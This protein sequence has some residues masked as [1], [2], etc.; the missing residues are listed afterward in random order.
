MHTSPEAA[1]FQ[2]CWMAACT[3]AARLRQRSSNGGAVAKY[4]FVCFCW[5][6]CVLSSVYLFCGRPF[7]HTHESAGASS[8]STLRCAHDAE[9]RAAPAECDALPVPA[10]EVLNS[11]SPSRRGPTKRGP[12]TRAP[13]HPFGVMQPM[14][15]RSCCSSGPPAWGRRFPARRHD[16]AVVRNRST[17]ALT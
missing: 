7:V 8:H 9:G 2:D 15:R 13:E 17:S 6:C 10:D 12:T 1:S 16:R 4:L 3:I 5:C 14:L 11:V